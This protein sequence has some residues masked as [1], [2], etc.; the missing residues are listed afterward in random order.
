MNFR[1]DILITQMLGFLIVFWVLRRYAW[2]P[3]MGMLEERRMRIATEVQTTEKLRREAEALKAEFE[4][5]LRNIEAQARQRI[6]EAVAEG[7]TV[8]EEIKAAAHTEAQAITQKAK[9]SVEMEYKR[10]RVE[11]RAEIVN[12]ALGAAERL[13]EKSLD[14]EEHRKMVDRFLTDLEKQEAR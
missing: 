3:L 12:T 1:Y 5:Q 2:G 6:Q 8:A 14:T 7:Q 10:A 11:L 13:L 4:N 9:A